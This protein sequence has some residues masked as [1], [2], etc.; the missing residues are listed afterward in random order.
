MYRFG[1]AS[2]SGVG[3]VSITGLETCMSDVV[4]F[5]AGVLSVGVAVDVCAA[6]CDVSAVGACTAVCEGAAVGVSVIAVEVISDGILSLPQAVNSILIAITAIH[7]LYTSLFDIN[8]FCCL[9]PLIEIH[10]AV[11]V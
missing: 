5:C 3:V 7:V 10:C 2:F 4:E 8:I 6:V 11:K 9:T 1:S